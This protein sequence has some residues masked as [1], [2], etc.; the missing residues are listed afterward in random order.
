MSYQNIDT[1][2]S[3]IG[4]SVS[5]RAITATL[6]VSPNGDDTD[7]STWTKAYTTIQGA[8]DVAST[9]ANDCTLILVAPHATY[10]NID[11]TGDP[12][13][14]GNYEIKGTHRLW[15]PV[16]NE[17][18]GATSIFKFTGKV[19]IEDL[20]LFSTDNG[21]GGSVGGVIF[22]KAGYR[23]RA[24]GF[25]SEATTHA[26]KSIHID[27]SAAFVRGGILDGIQIQGNVSYTTGLY[28]DTAKINTTEH[29]NFH[30]CLNA[31]QIVDTD[32]DGNYFCDLEIGDCNIGLNLDAGNEQHFEGIS[33]HGNTTNIDDEVGDH[34]WNNINGEFPITIEPTGGANYAGVAVSAGEDAYG[35][36]TEL[37]A[38]ATATRPFKVIGFKFE[39]S[40]E[41]KFLTRFSADSGTTFFNMDLTEVKKN[42]AA[43]ASQGTDFIFNKGTRISCSSG[44]EA[45]GKTIQVWLEIQEI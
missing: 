8:L 37:R 39:P 3:A 29:I 41:K 14:T 11:T 42:K 34:S 12:T 16:R 30:T 1:V 13:W 35:G 20:A 7:G 38:A 21:V 24:C 28:M 32:S 43:G 2:R 23:V 15:A 18:N 4:G 6:Y 22:T 31:I 10:Y 25:N 45:A 26:N 40:E 17:H 19:S 27:G 36:D 5:G 44:C 33:F 9:D